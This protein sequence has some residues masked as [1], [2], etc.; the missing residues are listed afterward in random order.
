MPTWPQPLTAAQAQAQLTAPARPRVISYQIENLKLVDY[1][2]EKL[3]EMFQGQMAKLVSDEVAEKAYGKY[4]WAGYK[5]TKYEAH[6]KFGFLKK[7]GF[8]SKFDG[9]LPK[10]LTLMK[11]MWDEGMNSSEYAIESKKF[12]EYIKENGGYKL[13]PSEWESK[14]ITSEE[15][16]LILLQDNYRL[17]EFSNVVLKII[18]RRIDLDI[19]SEKFMDVIK[20]IVINYFI[21]KYALLE[22]E[23]KLNW[24]ICP[25]V[26]IGE[27][28]VTFLLMLQDISTKLRPEECT[29]QR[30]LVYTSFGSGDLLHDYIAL[31]L[32]NFYGYNYFEVN[33]IDKYYGST[34]SKRT[35]VEPIFANQWLLFSQALMELNFFASSSDY[36]NSSSKNNDILIAIDITEWGVNS[37]AAI[38]AK[39][40]FDELI[41]KATDENSLIYSINNNKIINYHVEHAGVEQLEEILPF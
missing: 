8:V 41:N 4:F 33:F 28:I 3:M 36:I 18:Q 32:L 6:Y 35:V 40:D 39:S 24:C 17:V 20:H 23:A 2:I 11:I 22:N 29:N 15:I 27:R 21:Q 10:L 38:K 30:P 37:P 25:K 5:N 9:N 7:V 13:S 31:L 26:S 12:I 16:A 34:Y 19:T 1:W 14:N